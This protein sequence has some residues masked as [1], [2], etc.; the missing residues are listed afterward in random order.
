MELH[1]R[2]VARLLPIFMDS[3]SKLKGLLAWAAILTQIRP[4]A[5]LLC[6]HMLTSSQCGLSQTLQ[7]S[8]TKGGISALSELPASVWKQVL[9]NTEGTEFFT[10]VVVGGEDIACMLVGGS[11]VNSITEEYVCGV[12]KDN[13]QKRIK[14]L[15][16]RHPIMQLEHWPTSE[17]IKGIAGATTVPLVGAV[18]VRTTMAKAGQHTGTEIKVRFKITAK[19]TTYWAGMIFGGKTYST[20]WKWSLDGR[21]VD[22]DG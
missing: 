20:L 13:K 4:I 15:D 8:D 17:C 16:K 5:P 1:L 12:L 11:M 21:V 14:H 6:M 22:Y 19:G 2:S 9:N 18:D 3:S 7:K 10:R